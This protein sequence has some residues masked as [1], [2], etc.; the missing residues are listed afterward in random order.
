VQITVWFERDLT[1][2]L[3]A[4]FGKAR[5][6]RW[7]GPASSMFEVPPPADPSD[8]DPGSM[9]VI[10]PPGEGHA[11][12]KADGFDAFYAGFRRAVKAGDWAAVASMMTIPQVDW[13]DVEGA[14]MTV[15]IT[16]ASDVAANADDL[17]QMGLRDLVVRSQGDRACDL[18]RRSY[19]VVYGRER[20]T[21]SVYV[22]RQ[23]DGTWRVGGIGHAAHDLW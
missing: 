2:Q 16:Q 5:T 21:P 3:V 11:C 6:A 8:R 9:V 7:S 10:V 20:L 4:R 12:G 13:N 19:S 15:H 18:V 17:F 23:P 14:E 1:A 22:A